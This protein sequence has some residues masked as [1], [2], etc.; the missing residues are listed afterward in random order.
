VYSPGSV[1]KIVT[2]GSALEKRLFSPDDMIDP[3]SGS[4]TV[5]KHT[6]TDSHGV[7]RVSYS[8]ALAHSS[9]VCAIKTAMSVGREDFFGLVKKLGFGAKTGIELPGEINGI[10]RP[11]EKWNG[12]SLASMSIGYE[13]GVTALQMTS[14][15]ATIA[16]N[17][18]RVQPRII[19]E[20]RQFDEKVGSTT[21]PAKVEVVSAESAR[22]MRGMLKEVVTAGTAKL[23]QVPGYTVAGKTGTAWKFDEKLSERSASFFRLDFFGSFCVKTKRTEKGTKNQ[24]KK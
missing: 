10:V 19:R 12:D 23:A 13:I 24:L 20:I 11:V 15:F 7:G 21:D 18:V 8:Q 4:I 9:N 16:N 22:K 1:F 17:G 6:F 3:G 2:Y 5:A 14:A